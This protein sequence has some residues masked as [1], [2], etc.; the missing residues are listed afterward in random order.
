MSLGKSYYL[1]F[2]VTDRCNLR[3]TYCLPERA[4][5]S[6]D[7][8]DA[9]RL[10]QLVSLICS[11][12][13]VNKIRVTGGEPTLSPHLLSH[14]RHS[15]SLVPL[16]AMTSNGTHLADKLE[17]LKEAGLSR[18][19]ISLDAVGEAG[20]QKFSRRM[21]FDAVL[22]AIKKAKNLGFSPLKVNAV[23]TRDTDAAALV[24]LAVAEGFHLRFIELMKIGEGATRWEE[25]FVT[26]HDLRR[27][28]SAAG[29]SLWAHPEQDEPTSRVYHHEG[30]DAAHSTV[31][32]ITTVTAPFC[33]TCNRIRLTSRGRFYTC[34]FDAKGVDLMGALIHEGEDRV[35]DL[36]R[37]AAGAKAPPL[38]EQK[39]PEVMAGIGG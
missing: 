11:A 3:C 39:R 7:P 33:A 37:K 5:F 6:P 12:L 24:H 17:D 29:F 36:I 30:V 13:P 18:L 38:H 10:N 23:A 19:N 22:A 14:V 25:N 20:F 32:F 26:A 9:D 1:R 15:T 16:V 27:Q 34:L 8:V 2:S 31:G 4:I 35:R 28:L 21:G